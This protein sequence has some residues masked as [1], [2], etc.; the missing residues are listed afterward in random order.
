MKK[1]YFLL[2]ISALFVLSNSLF[3]QENIGGTPLSFTL[4]GLSNSIEIIDLPVPDVSQFSEEDIEND[5][6]HFPQRIATNIQVDIGIS[7]GGTWE[8]LSSGGKIW[9]LKISCGGALALSVQFDKFYLPEG[10]KLFLY[11]EEKTQ[12]LGAFTSLNN[13]E[14]GLFSTELIQGDV[15]ILEYLEL[16]GTTGITELNISEIAYAYR[17]VSFVFDNSKD[18]GDSDWCQVNVNCSPEGNNW[19][20]EKR[21]VARI[22]FKEGSYWYWCT[23]SLVNNTS[24]DGTPYFLT[25]DHCGGDASAYDRNQWI[26]YFNYESSGCSNPSSSPTYNSKTGATLKARGN[27]Q[28]GSDFQLV[29]INSAI[30]SYY[31]V[32]YNGWDKSGSSSTSGVGI[33]HPSGDIKKIST[34]SSTLSSSTWNGSG[35]IGATNAHWRTSWISTTNGYGVTE[36]GSSG[37]PIFNS[38]GRIL[39]TLTGGSTACNDPYWDY[40]GK[41]SYHWQSN[42]TSNSNRLKPWLDPNNT[43]VN[44][45]NG[46]DPNAAAP[47]VANFSANN[48]S[49][50]TGL[51]VYFNDLSTNNPTSW[52]WSFSPPTVTYVGGT[53]SSSE[54]PQVQF[55]AEGS[56]SVT[57]T[58]TN[59]SGSDSETK[60]NYITV[61]SGPIADFIADNTSPSL[62]ETVSFFDFSQNS[63]ISWY[64][65]FNPS[66]ITYVGGSSSNSQNPQVQFNALGQYTVTLIVSNSAGND[67]EVKDDYISVA[68]PPI[69]D[70]IADNNTPLVG[71]TVYFY[72]FSQNTPTSWSWSFD[73]PSISYVEGT[74]S[75]SQNPEVHFDEAGYYTVTLMASNVAGSDSET[76]VNYILAVDQ[77][78]ADFVVDNTSPATGS[79][80]YFSDLSQ[81]NP[82]SWSWTFDPPTISFAGGTSSTSQNPEV[83]FSAGGF[84]TVTLTVTNYV[85]S[86]SETK[87]DYISVVEPPV[88]DFTVDNNAPPIGSTVYFYDLSTNDPMSWSWSFDPATVSYVGGTSSTSQDPEVQFNSGGL[89]TVTLTASNSAGSDDEEKVDYISVLYVPEVDFEA[90]NTTPFTGELVHFS[91]LSIND[92]ASWEWTFDPSTISYSGG[93]NST[94]QHPQV[95]F[96]IPGSYAVE[97]TATNASGSDTETKFDYIL[98][99]NAMIDLEITVF[100]EGPFNGVDMSSNLIAHLPLNQPY[101]IAP[102]NY[103]GTESVSTFPNSN[104]VDWVLIELRDA[105]DAASATPATMMDRQAAFV[106][107]DGKIVDLDGISNLQF[108]NNLNDQLFIVIWHRNHLG[109]LSSGNLVESGGIYTYNFSIGPNQV[110]GNENGHKEIYP[111]I[112]GMIGGDGNHDGFVTETDKAPTWDNQAGN[113]GYLES[114]YN[115]DAQSDNKDKDDIWSPNDG[116]G[117]QVP[118]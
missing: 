5:K 62:G 23:G 59:S 21:G 28:G 74:T 56:Y 16:A 11:N 3:S 96:N 114:D 60:Y 51:T 79:S 81:N 69:A 24:L 15:V 58:A 82:T 102:W 65:S 89:Y 113:E 91:D 38:S 85:G 106:L 118:N 36:G 46:Y 2:V 98:V 88:A 115:L 29:Q 8:N 94:S 45:L 67:T 53:N 70:F 27:I 9:R 14:A 76:K 100:L 20:D 68:N 99:E 95:I 44:Y 112:W 80:V 12:V 41:F 75:S 39:G 111:G 90:D 104:I 1:N 66:T 116:K 92:P 50:G 54:N 61:I 22:L 48:T 33:H 72:D 17:N 86:D 7:N 40:Y 110:H 78:V 107:N 4:S 30:P 55:N 108:E 117:C 101:N 32:Y 57:L 97:L 83:Q 49:P 52:S 84:Y 35:Y 42:G 103:F 105:S 87:V 71:T 64:W 37:S 73:P 6:N 43:G 34:Y 25:A 18:F 93:T 13:N 63:P 77:P 31:N 109:V 19:Q 10:N 26:F 47:P